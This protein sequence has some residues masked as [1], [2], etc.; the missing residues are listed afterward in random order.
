[1]YWEEGRFEIF[2]EH[3]FTELTKRVLRQ[4]VVALPAG[5]AM[6]PRVLLATVPEEPHVLG[7]LMAETLFALEGAECIPM[8]AQMP[9]LEIVR[10]ALAHQADVVALSFSVSFPLR[11]ITGVLQALRQSLPDGVRLWVGG[12]GVRR[13]GPLHGVQVLPTLEA[14][15]QAL[16]EFQGR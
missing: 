15:L 8:G 12:G 6:R 13:L 2:E 11:K 9:V 14:S 5:G 7:L 3:L 4:S 10:A 1:V 16:R